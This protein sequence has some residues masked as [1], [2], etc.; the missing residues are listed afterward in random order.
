MN[1]NSNRFGIWRNGHDASDRTWAK[2]DM[3]MIIQ[4]KKSIILIVWLGPT[5]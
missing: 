4:R 5:N 1:L 2:N 3:M